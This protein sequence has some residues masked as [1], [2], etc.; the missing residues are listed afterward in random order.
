MTE[1]TP[2]PSDRP[3]IAVLS[4]ESLS[5]DPEQEY[6]AGGVAE[7]I[8]AGLA[9]IKGLLVIGRNSSFA[10]KGKIVDVKQIGR[11]LGAQYVLI[12]SARQS[13]GRVRLPPG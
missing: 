4:F 5:D 7:E 12:G 13:S 11:E 10:Y 9:R 1:A 8:I 3:S 2:T 6:F